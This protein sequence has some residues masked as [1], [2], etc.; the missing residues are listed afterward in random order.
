LKVQINF[1]PGKCF[2]S[3]FCGGGR[4]PSAYKGRFRVINFSGNNPG[5]SCGTK[6]REKRFS[7]PGVF[8][9]SATGLVTFFWLI[10][11]LFFRCFKTNKKVEN[12]IIFMFMLQNLF[13]FLKVSLSNLFNFSFLFINTYV[14]LA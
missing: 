1:F 14:K 5:F 11:K 13:F 6:T 2:H 10:E 12:A 3:V 8:F 7:S 9:M 4:K